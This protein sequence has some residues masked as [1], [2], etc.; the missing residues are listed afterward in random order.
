MKL[1]H[2]T[3]TNNQVKD[4][5]GKTVIGKN[6][7]PEYTR[8]FEKHFVTDNEFLG[9]NYQ[10]QSK[11]MGLPNLTITLPQE[12]WYASKPEDTA[13]EILIE[14]KDGT[15]YQGEVTKK[16]R[17]LY[18]GTI[19]LD[20][21]HIFHEC[22]HVRVPTNYGINDATLKDLFS[23]ADK[24]KDKDNKD[25]ENPYKNLF[26]HK[27]WTYELDDKASKTKITYLCSNQSIEQILTDICQL[28]DDIFWRVSLTKPRTI[29]IGTF[30]KDSKHIIQSRNVLGD[31][32]QMID[33]YQDLVNYAIYM[34]DKSDSGT[35]ALTLRDVYNKKELINKDFPIILTGS[36]INTERN[37]NYPDLIVFGANNKNDYAVMDKKGIELEQGHIF[38]SS[39]TAND[40][41]TVAKD[42][43]E[44]TDEERLAASKQLYAKAIR[45][46]KHSR[47]KTGYTFSVDYLPK[48]INVGDQVTI[49]FI[50][51]I[52]NQ[53]ECSKAT[54]K[55]LAN[56]KLY[57]SN[58]TK[59]IH[60]QE[61]ITYN[62]T[63][64]TM[65][66]NDKEV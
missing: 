51:K 17:D 49:E 66:Y 57:I 40:I 39:F 12:V 4:K 56:G 24:L 44:L 2:V 29:E 21:E 14:F 54:Y 35:T 59:Q 55:L 52:L 16:T 28:T 61:Y 18:Q 6:G 36:E 30:C 32:L 27:D 41:Q 5:S 31:S 60:N 65:I 34:T 38:E 3:S 62:L 33:D 37:Y 45:K 22:S 42:N 1:Y 64:E 58:I 11:I 10:I 20:T 8:Q 48:E 15:I 19:Q 53:S 43:K 13:N 23:N 9:D 46:L 26:R 7:L 63:A 47:R 25:I 50:N